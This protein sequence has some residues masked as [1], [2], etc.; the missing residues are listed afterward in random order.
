MKRL[1]VDHTPGPW[2]SAI[3]DNIG[4]YEWTDQETLDITADS[5]EEIK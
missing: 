1:K 4:E 2:T 3:E 5:C